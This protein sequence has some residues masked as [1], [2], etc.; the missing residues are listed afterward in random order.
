MYDT[1]SRINVPGDGHCFLYALLCS[2]KAQLMYVCADSELIKN[3]IITEFFTNNDTYQ[4]FFSNDDHIGMRRELFEYVFDKK[5]NSNVCDILPFITSNAL[6]INLMI[7]DVLPENEH[8][9]PIVVNCTSVPNRNEWVILLRTGM[10]FDGFQYCSNL[11]F[12]PVISPSSLAISNTLSY[13]KIENNQTD[14]SCCPE[15]SVTD[16]HINIGICNN[17]VPHETISNKVKKCPCHLQSN[18]IDHDLC[19]CRLKKKF[20]KH[21]GLKYIHINARSFFPKKDEI[22]WVINE[23]NVDACLISETWL[24]TNVLDQDIVLDGYALIRNDRQNRKGGGVLIYVKNTIAFKER[25]D[26]I[27][28]ECLEMIWL[29]ITTQHG[30]PN[31]LLSCLYRPPNSNIDYFNH[32]I[33]TI[34][35]ASLDSKEI[36]LMGDINIDYTI[37]ENMSSNSIFLLESMF[38][39]KQ[40]VLSPTRVTQST[41]SILDL[42][43]STCPQHHTTTG[44]HKL[45]LSDH[46]M[47]Y[48]CINIIPNRRGHRELKYRSYKNFDESQCLA[49][50]QQAYQNINDQFR[51]KNTNDT[52]HDILEHNWNHWKMLFLNVSNTHAPI[53][54]SRLKNRCS[55]WISPDIIKCMYSR[56]H[57]HK[58]AIKSNDITRSN[59]YW[60]EYRRLRNLV[61][62]NV[63]RAKQIYFKDA[64]SKNNKNPKQLWKEISRILPRKNSTQQL[65]DISPNTFNTY[66]SSIGNDVANKIPQSTL[67]DEYQNN[68]PSSIHTFEFKHIDNASTLKLLKSLPNHSKIDILTF[69]TRLLNLAAHI[70]S[71]SLTH[72]LNGSLD[73]GYV[74]NDWK[75]AQVSPAYKGKGP[76]I[77]ENNYRPLSV[78]AA[79]AKIAEK[80]VQLQLLTYLRKFKFI[81]IDQY[82]YLQHHST[83]LCLHR[84]FDDILEN[85]NVKEHT[86]LCF[87]DIKK[88]FDTIDHDLLLF[89]LKKYGIH[90]NEYNW[91]RS[92]LSDRTQV[93]TNNGVISDKCVMNIG[94]PQGTILGPILFLLFINDLPNFV[95]NAQLNIYA[96]DV[97]IYCSSTDIR[98]A[99]LNLQKV[100]SRVYEWYTI[101][102]LSLS[103]EKCCTML[104]PGN[105]HVDR[106]NFNISVGNKILDHVHSM[107]Y[108]GVTIDDDLKW[109]SHLTNISKKIN[110]NNARIRKIGK[111]LPQAVKLK[112]H[113]SISL[114][115]LDYASTV[116]GNFSQSILQYM[117][118]LEHKC[119]RSITGNF[120]YVNTRGADLMKLTN[121]SYFRNRLD[122]FTSVI[123]YKAIHGLAPDNIAN[124]VLFTYEVSNRNLRTFDNMDLYKPRPFCDLFKK[125]LQYYGPTTWNSLPLCIKESESVDTFKSSYKKRLPLNRFTF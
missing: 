122:Y 21:K 1:Y 61:N 89:K 49:D 28:N 17:N 94:V 2:M 90:N 39:F 63:K 104:I 30:S 46:Y 51:K 81:T 37:N 44:V 125:S 120:D 26:I 53:K 18:A 41:S 121:M 71:P 72:L 13:D 50:F 93:V 66:F 84:L 33:D 52:D 108:L 57:F 48:T 14:T 10:H 69:D 99:Q 106:S 22:H 25:F 31:I 109:R 80:N 75:L 123:M 58:K 100:M 96:D 23:L 102:K 29:E 3:A 34:E 16:D 113:N 87:I 111:I 83:Q 88:C 91:F 54:V 117:N 67:L 45:T 76:V 118:R 110:M 107:K 86:G 55:T 112:V 62:K 70:I 79:I 92:Y 24:D 27:T 38:G 98:E 47:V 85:I 68:F 42:I 101:N 7:L 5:Y 73:T 6:G 59:T 8:I 116:W 36:I 77:E 124:N 119:A 105:N 32:I 20:K 78:I 65:N 9:N 97:V 74:P 11:M 15:M 43:L 4:P 114:P 56:D 12:P 82:A 40:L 35:K 19:I 60:Q 64:C 103:I 115:V 95:Q